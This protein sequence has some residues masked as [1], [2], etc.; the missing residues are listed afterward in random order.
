[1]YSPAAISIAAGAR[2]RIRRR[3]GRSSEVTGSSNQRISA[4][5]QRSAKRSACLDR[6]RAIGIDKELAL[7]DRG[8]GDLHAMRIAVRLA[9][10]FH[11]DEAAAVALDPAGELLREA[12]RPNRW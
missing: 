4:R 8:L 11:L 10:D 7:A 2:S 9:A 3:P 1:M 5:A 12:G 6:K